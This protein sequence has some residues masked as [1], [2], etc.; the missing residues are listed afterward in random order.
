MRLEKAQSDRLWANAARNG[1]S[2]PI[3]EYGQ[4]A[5]HFYDLTQKDRMAV[6]CWLFLNIRPAK[7]GTPAAYMTSQEVAELASFFT[8]ICLNSTQA[9]EA[10]L[11]LA[12]APWDASGRDWVY[13]VD[14]DSPCAMLAPNGNGG[15]VRTDR[16]CHVKSAGVS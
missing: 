16:S 8:G 12:I 4:D 14:R 13:R 7:P 2:V 15:L 6:S 5:P 3:V 10:L 1:I 9:R 11:L